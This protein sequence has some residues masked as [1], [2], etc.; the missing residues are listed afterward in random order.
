MDTTKVRGKII[1]TGFA[2][3]MVLAGCSGDSGGDDSNDQPG[4]AA[5]GLDGCVE[6]PDTCNAGE[7]AEGGTI[8][9]LINQG[10][11]ASY[12]PLTADG[13]SVYMTQMREGIDASVGIFTPS[14]DWAYN[15]DLL[16]S[17]PELL[18]EDPL[19]VRYAI[20][21]EAVWSDGEPINI[22]DVRF[23]QKHQSGKEEDCSD[24]SPASTSFYDT[25]VSI[26][27]ED[28]AGKV[29]TITYEDG[30]AHPEWF[31]RGLFTHPAHIA[32]AEG[33]DW[34]SDPDDMAAASEF[35]SE[36]VPTWSSGPYVVESWVVDETQVLVPNEN[37]YGATQPTLDSIV[38]EVVSDQP[39]WVPATSNRELHGGAPASFTV[40]LE[41]QLAD[42]PG[43]TTGINPNTYSWDHVDMNMESLSDVALRRAIFTAIDTEDARERI[44][45]DLD[46]LPAMRTGLFLPQ[47]NEYHQDHLTETGYG[48]GN[49][50]AA[51]AILDEA[52]YT[53][54]EEGG[55]LTDPNGDPVPDL[56][57]AFLSGNE[58]RNT[59][60][61]LAQSYLADIGVTI[62]PDPTPGDRL[63]TV[64]VEADYDLITFG[65]SGNPLI[66]N[67]PHQYYHSSSP[68]NFG[69]LN[70]PEVD[71]LVEEARNQLSLDDTSALHQQTI[72]LVLDEAYILPLWDTPD[73]VWVS[74][75]YANIRD[76]SAF[77][78]RSFYNIAEWGV[79][80][81]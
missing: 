66:A 31:A 78:P 28:D 61:Q 36:T 52:G 6:S 5:P 65:W 29:I 56:R 13:S 53:G 14:G 75:E 15:H 46:E 18:G 74:D 59:F 3:A 30:W 45:G 16:E 57:F 49:A 21:E 12:N 43:I 41:Q 39:S 71:R 26:E 63:G 64:L 34:R 55:T 79:R 33:F 37:W 48:T 19:T 68:S 38:K 47:S 22:D 27:A 51:R 58:N 60:V 72:E 25:T 4:D 9:Y 35:F 42:I 23:Q 81:D 11:D 40:D 77:S 17:D 24:C 67:G 2:T 62:T 80:A 10:H 76:N 50:E 70:N 69:G 1:A 73:L 44:W 7:R 8:T 20:R 32:D 54:F